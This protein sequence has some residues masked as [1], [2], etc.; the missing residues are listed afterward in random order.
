MVGAISCTDPRDV[1]PRLSGDGRS[2]NA[3][4][5]SGGD[6][7]GAPRNVVSRRHVLPVWPPLTSRRDN[8]VDD[9]DDDD[10]DDDYNIRVAQSSRAEIG[11]VFEGDTPVCVCVCV[12][13]TAPRC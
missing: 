6:V 9:E 2:E 13:T 3:T 7:I 5:Y 11:P 10:D 4:S 1:Y 12:W 8:D